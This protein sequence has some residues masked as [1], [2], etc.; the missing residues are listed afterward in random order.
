[1]KSKVVPPYDFIFLEWLDATRS[2]E[3]MLPEEV[4]ECAKDDQSGLIREGGWL[5]KETK[6]YLVIAANI[7]ESLNDRTDNQFNGVSRIPKTWIRKRITLLTMD[8]NGSVTL[9]TQRKRRIAGRTHR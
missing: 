3:W 7:G 8:E 2:S 1:M 6:H 9:R 4:D 5:L